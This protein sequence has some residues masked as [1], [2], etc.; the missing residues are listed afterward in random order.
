M[1]VSW[2]F[3][4]PFR[5][6]QPHLPNFTCDSFF[7]HLQDPDHSAKV[8]STAHE[9]INNH[10]FG[11]FSFQ[12]NWTTMC[13]ISNSAHWED[14]PFPLS[15]RDVPGRDCY[16]VLS[17]T[18]HYLH[19]WLLSWLPFMER[20]AGLRFGL[21]DSKLE[22][23]QNLTTGFVVRSGARPNLWLTSRLQNSIANA[24]RK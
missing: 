17:T 4:Y 2:C 10:T 9:F 24:A 8:L 20:S 15:S 6:I 19:W 14:F 5:E 21:S 3:F 18:L 12:A 22:K 16:S 7:N 1:Q 13:T 11:H 23:G